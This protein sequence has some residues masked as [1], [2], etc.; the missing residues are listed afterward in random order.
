M[1][2]PGLRQQIAALQDQLASTVKEK[3]ATEMLSRIWLAI[4]VLAVIFGLVFGI[5]PHLG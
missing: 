1:E 5:Q 3:R 4:T 2:A